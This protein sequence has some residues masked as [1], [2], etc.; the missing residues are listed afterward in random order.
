MTPAGNAAVISHSPPSR[1]LK[2]RLACSFSFS[3]VSRKISA[4]CSKPAFLATPEK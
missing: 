1:K 4:I 2:K 3:A